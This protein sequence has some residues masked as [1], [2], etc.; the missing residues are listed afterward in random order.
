MLCPPESGHLDPVGLRE[1]TRGTP[2]LFVDDFLVE[3]R[4]DRNF[5]SA[6]VPHVAHPVRR[7]EPFVLP[8]KPWEAEQGCGY[9]GVVFDPQT[10]LFRLY[11]TVYHKI[12]RGRPDYPGSYFLCYAQSTDGLDWEKPELGLFPWG[13]W[14]RTNIV[15][16][17]QTEVHSGHVHVG[18][19]EG[20]GRVRNIGSL[21]EHLLKG[22]R[23]VMY[24]CDVGHYLA[25]SEDGIHWQERANQLIANRIDCFHTLVYDE[26]RDECVSFLRNKLIFGGLGVPPDLQ[27]NTRAISRLAGP[28][29]WSRWDRMPTAVLIPDH[30]DAKR[31]YSMST[32]RYGEVYWGLLHQF[33]ED[34]QTLQVELVFSRD[35]IDWKRLPG[36]PLL[37]PV[38]EPGTWDAGMI[39]AADR[40][41][42]C[43]DEWWIYYS[44]ADHYHNATPTPRAIGLAKVR[45]EGFV[46]LRAGGEESYV[47]TRPFHWPGGR[48]FI[49]AAAPNGS[50][51]VRV[52]DLRRQLIAGFDYVDC[53][54]FNGDAVRHPVTWSGADIA[55]LEGELIRLEFKF[56]NADLFAFVATD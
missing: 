16:Q 43:D 55:A 15:L 4:F 34:P 41:I 19:G 13:E 37:I 2:Q 9:P 8:D 48:L 20:G 12:N 30:G 5:L 28:D 47:L 49:N 29:L 3:N 54:P 22:H 7:G 53:E 26:K 6:N 31:F 14:R 17:G 27:G 46:S 50:V 44:G 32:F 40:L 21:P 24:Y 51:R 11:Y 33:D 56:D 45:K 35:G 38:G 1:V 36:R 10:R 23:M 42:E 25:T 18:G 39:M 52:T